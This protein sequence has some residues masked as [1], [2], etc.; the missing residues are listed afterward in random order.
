MYLATTAFAVSGELASKLWLW[1]SAKGG[2][3]YPPHKSIT[4][5]AFPDGADVN[6]PR[7][8]CIVLSRKPVP[9]NHLPLIRVTEGA[10]VVRA[11]GVGAW[12]DV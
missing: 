9:S 8:M 1:A 2:T 11:A 4:E 12:L 7:D 10:S 6:T 5:S 3:T